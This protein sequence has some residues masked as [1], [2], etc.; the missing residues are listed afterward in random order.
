V[1]S[2]VFVNNNNGQL[3]A[4]YELTHNLI[5]PL[6]IPTRTIITTFH[7]NVSSDVIKIISDTLVVYYRGICGGFFK[8]PILIDFYEDTINIVVRWDSVLNATPG[9][10]VSLNAYIQSIDIPLIY[11]AIDFNIGMDYKLFY[12]LKLYWLNGETEYPLSFT[13]KFADGITASAGY[14]ELKS[15]EKLLRLEGMTMLSKPTASP[16]SFNNFDITTSQPYILTLLDGW[17]DVSNFCGN[18]WR[19][20]VKFIPEYDVEI[21]NVVDKNILQMDFTSEGEVLI[22]IEILDIDGNI[23]LTEKLNL[24][25]GTTTELLRLHNISSGKYFIKFTNPL[26]YSIT[27]QF[28]IVR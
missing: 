13:Y 12:P 4:V 2:A 15:G 28:I 7:I 23:V 18:D 19:G 14:K 22:R 21:E 11:D 27:M 9:D 10:T 5:V 17:L 16:V 8:I 25:K 3:P 20:A 6:N 1:D 26:D 24:Q